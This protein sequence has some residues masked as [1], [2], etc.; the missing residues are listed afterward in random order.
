M[1]RGRNRRIRIFSGGAGAAAARGRLALGAVILALAVICPGEGARAR[2]AGQEQGDRGQDQRDNAVF[3]REHA[4]AARLLSQKSF[5]EAVRVLERLHRDH[6]QSREVIELLSKCYLQMGRPAQ[7]ISFLEDYLRRNPPSFM[8][9]RNLGEA[10]LD[11]GE[12]EQ[13]VRVWHSILEGDD[14]SG[15]YYGSVAKMEWDAGMYDRALETLREG[16]KFEKFFIQNSRELIRLEML[17]DRSQDAFRDELILLSRSGELNLRQASGVLES[18][19]EAGL[20]ADLLSLVDSMAVKG[21]RHSR[22]FRYLHT[23]M[24]VERDEYEEAR[25]YVR[26]SAAGGEED[27]EAY[28]FAVQLFLMKHKRGQRDFEAFLGE[29]I[30]LFMERYKATHLAPGMI[31]LMTERQ[32]ETAAADPGTGRAEYERI[33]RMLEELVS[34]PLG[35]PY[36]QKA[37]LLKAGVELELLGLPGEALTTLGGAIRRGRTTSPAL[38]ELR[39]RALLASGR[40]SEA[41]KNLGR[42]AGSPDSNLA[43]M[44]EYGLGKMFFLSGKYNRA[45][46]KLSALAREHPGSE[47]ANDALEIA[48]LTKESLQEGEAPLNLFTAGLRVSLR[49]GYGEAADSL[50]ALQNRYKGSVLVPRSLWVGSAW[51]RSAGRKEEARGDLQRLCELYPLHELAPRALERLGEYW[52]AEDPAAAAGYYARALDR[53]PDDPFADRVRS[54][55]IRIRKILPPGGEEE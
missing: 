22:F 1:N 12:K 49:G 37:A 14:D 41:E 32:L 45:V 30:D 43:V 8:M 33:R 42:L 50:E 2:P 21:E 34:H 52:E 19:R 28:G 29:T 13:A 39:M 23:L 4:R 24:L 36:L 17:L 53:Y 7:A 3:M 25:A 55:Y 20:P 27:Q 9:I 51:K 18:F 38:E 35:G 16:T 6:P 44:G 46:D 48:I 40:W 31:Y 5:N 54:R 26:D 47:W 15:Q 11:T 10:Y